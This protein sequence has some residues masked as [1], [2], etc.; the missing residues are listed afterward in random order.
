M[1]LTKLKLRNVPPFK[2][3]ELDLDFRGITVI[4]GLNKDASKN[5]SGDKPVTNAAGKSVLVGAL[6]DLVI[7]DTPTGKDDAKAKKKKGKKVKSLVEVEG[8]KAGKHYTITKRSENGKNKEF[9]ILRDGK[10]IHIRTVDY[11]QKRIQK[12]FGLNEAN[13][14]SRF[15]IDST[16]PHPLIAGSSKKGRP[17]YIAELFNLNDVDHVKKLLSAEMSR[18]NKKNIELR[19]LKA[20]L[21][22]VR[23]HLK[24][25]A[26]RL[27]LKEKIADLQARQEGLG[28]KVVELQ[29]VS[30][31]VAFERQNEKLISRLSKILDGQFESLPEELSKLKKRMRKIDDLRELQAEWSS[32][33]KAKA[34]YLEQAESVLKAL[35]KSGFDRES[36]KV[37]VE[38]IQNLRS[39]AKLLELSVKQSDPGDKPKKPESEKPKDDPKVYDLKIEALNQELSHVKK[40]KSGKC[41]TCG[42]KVH[43]RSPEDIQSEVQKWSKKARSAHAWE[44]YLGQKSEWTLLVRSHEQKTEKLEKLREQLKGTEK[45]LDLYERVRSLP[46]APRKPDEELPPD[47]IDNEQVEKLRRKI[48]DLSAGKDL[49]TLILDCQKLTD[50]QRSLPNASTVMTELNG[51]NSQLLEC[52]SE[53]NRQSDYLERGRS[54]KTRVDALSEEVKDLKIIKA[55][56][57]AYSKQGL[58][59]FM[60]WRQSKLLEQ[61]INKYRKIFFVEDYSFEFQQSGPNLSLLVNRKYGKK[62]STSDVKRLSGAEKRLFTLLLV[63]ATT[64]CLPVNQ[65][66]NVLVLDE[67][68]ANMGKAI[69]EK[70]LSSLPVLNKLFEHILYVT[71][72]DSLI[73]PNSRVFTVIKEN[74]VA[75][76]TKTKEVEA[77]G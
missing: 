8:V 67:P 43:A 11:T 40:F 32:Y 7:D 68:E 14:Y 77:H 42:S 6:P 21:D 60:I 65:R 38:R 5:T 44:S 30:D 57:S 37:E 64:T 41:P 52:K 53:Y 49:L 59:R 33:K 4:R 27:A 50:K 16:I 19:T 45:T 18:L 20:E 1:R 61:Q 62:T 70:L 73:I 25:K 2:E 66:P 26:E 15:Y 76:L 58:K 46:A 36:L 28:K 72:Q 3:A 39:E 51:L 31:T 23:L 35:K 74:G 56:V 55:F 13:F 63:V 69:V 34:L 10:D 75:R 12:I 54:L 47:A 17:D 29:W 71:P 48:S 9:K 22:D 24:P